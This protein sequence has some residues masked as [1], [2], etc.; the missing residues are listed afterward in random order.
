M[1][2]LIAALL[3]AGLGG[4]TAWRRRGDR[5]DIAQ[6]AVGFAIFFALL[7]LL[8]VIILGRTLG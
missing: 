1:I 2:I 4:I 6:Y 8:G 3:G 7:S 5:L